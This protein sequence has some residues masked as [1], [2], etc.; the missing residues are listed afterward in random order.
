MLRA[1]VNVCTVNAALKDGPEAF[2]GVARW[3]RRSIV[4]LLVLIPTP[5]FGCDT[6]PIPGGTKQGQILL[7]YSPPPVI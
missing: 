5:D 1:N 7:S 4:L 3:R 2:N 6:V